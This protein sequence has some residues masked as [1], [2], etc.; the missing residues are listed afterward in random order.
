MNLLERFF[1]RLPPTDRR[2]LR[3][4]I[5]QRTLE[6]ARLLLLQEDN[7]E[8]AKQNL[9]WAKQAE[10]TLAATARPL[11]K[12]SLATVIALICVLAIHWC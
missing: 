2:E 1:H 6:A 4:G 11:S 8:A 10:Q 5:E 12:I 9:E 3:E 7:T